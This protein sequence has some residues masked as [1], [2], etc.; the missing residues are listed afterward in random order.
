MVEVDHFWSQHRI[1][2]HLEE[3]Q[4]LLAE[5]DEDGASPMITREDVE[6]TLEAVED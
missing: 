5:G 3:E 4:V 2:R 1:T 6:D